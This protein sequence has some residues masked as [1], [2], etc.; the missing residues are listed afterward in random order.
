MEAEDF[1]WQVRVCGGV[2]GGEGTLLLGKESKEIPMAV[3]NTDLGCKWA[4]RTCEGH[5]TF[6]PRQGKGRAAPGILE[7]GLLVNTPFTAHVQSRAPPPSSSRRGTCGQ[8]C[9]LER[10]YVLPR[11][12]S[13][14]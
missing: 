9:S 10:C 2:H 5:K 3:V 4:E 12:R 13:L 7:E 1:V 8:P 14:P 11:T 6:G